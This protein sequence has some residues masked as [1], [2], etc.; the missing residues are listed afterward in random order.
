VSSVK[1]SKHRTWLSVF[2]CN[3]KV[4]DQTVCFEKIGNFSTL[5]P[6]SERIF[7]SVCSKIHREVTPRTVDLLLSP[8]TPNSDATQS[9]TVTPASHC[10]TLFGSLRLHTEKHHHKTQILRTLPLPSTHSERQVL[11]NAPESSIPRNLTTEARNTIKNP[12]SENTNTCA[13]DRRNRKAAKPKSLKDRQ[14]VNE[15]CAVCD[16]SITLLGTEKTQRKRARFE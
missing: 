10:K 7:G 8:F 5:P 16:L 1:T 9:L 13:A 3:S 4:G 2:D 15:G 11:L 14:I 12:N 6:V